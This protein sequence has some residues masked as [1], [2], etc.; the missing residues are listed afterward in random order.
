MKASKF[1]GQLVVGA[2]IAFGLCFQ[3]PL[4]GQESV[5]TDVSS[6]RANELFAKAQEMAGAGQFTKAIS[7]QTVALSILVKAVGEDDLTVQL[8]S[9]RLGTFLLDNG[10]LEGG[11]RLLVELLKKLDEADPP[12]PVAVVAIRA[13]LASAFVDLH[14]FVEAREMLLGT[15][16][17]AKMAY[18]DDR[19]QFLH[20]AAVAAHD[21]QRMGDSQK[22]ETL[23]R[24]VV[25]IAEELP[26]CPRRFLAGSHKSLASILIE[27]NKN[28]EA[29]LELDRAIE[30]GR[31]GGESCEV[32]LAVCLNELATLLHGQAD[33]ESAC[34]NY[35]DAVLLL[36]KLHPEGSMTCSVALSN[37]GQ[38]LVSQGKLEEGMDRLFES[39]DMAIKYREES[40]LDFADILRNAS[41]GAFA[42]K[43]YDYAMLAATE[44]CKLFKAIA[45]ETDHRTGRALYNI[46]LNS[47]F[48]G[49]GPT[50]E[51]F[52]S[53]IKILD[54][55]LL[56]ENQELADAHEGLGIYFSGTNNRNEALRHF[57][58]CIRYASRRL[59]TVLPT[60]PDAEQA[61]YVDY[62]LRH[63][64]PVWTFALENAED[65][66]VTQKSAEWLTNYKWLGYESSARQTSLEKLTKDSKLTG[67]L[68]EL[69]N[70][71][72]AYAMYVP[73]VDE[74]AEHRRRYT[75]LSQQLAVV[76]RELGAEFGTSTAVS[77]WVSL[78][79]LQQS[80]PNNAV[81]VDILR[82]VP[83][84]FDSTTKELVVLPPH[85][86]AW[87]VGG[88]N[89]KTV[90]VVDLGEAEAIDARILNIRRWFQTTTDRDEIL[91]L[92]GEDVVATRLN[93]KLRELARKI[94]APLAQ[95]LEGKEELILSP[96]KELWLAP[97]SALPVD[98][99]GKVLIEKVAIRLVN[100]GRQLTTPTIA[101]D[102]GSNPPV[103]I[104]DPAYDIA[105]FADKQR[106]DIPRENGSTEKTL[107]PGKYWTEQFDRLRGRSDEPRIIA[108][109][110][111]Q[112]N[113]VTAELLLGER[114]SESEV[115][116]IERPSVLCF[117]T[118]GIFLPDPSQF[119]IESPGLSM[120]GDAR[121]ARSRSITRTQQSELDAS[122][123]PLLR[124]GLIL[125]GANKSK[126]SASSFGDGILTGLEI[127]GLDLRGTELVVLSACDSANGEIRN[128]EGVS[129]LQ[130][131]FHL[132]GARYVLGALWGVD[133]L[134]TQVITKWFFENLAAGDSP[135]AALRN[136]QLKWIEDRRANI[137]TPHPA[138]WSGL[139][140]SG[141]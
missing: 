75:E 61:I 27:S 137:G 89:S 52:R 35:E 88:Q 44:S 85:Y 30:I 122:M 71:I 126:T 87:I 108:S 81:F 99:Q 121:N 20:Y 106:Q 120:Q 3:S 5:A 140:I 138:F 43:R 12:D 118:H 59:Q 36:R 112:R 97:W 66:D 95:Y 63:L 6:Q 10:Q 19:M 115:F 133:D 25:A 33:F 84:K 18:R 92:G 2:V 47:M 57:D 77:P 90:G 131:A 37:Y 16:D 69:R 98:D 26:D 39:V 141:N 125:A 4:K 136:A 114:A 56:P 34:K 32:I 129:G 31:G 107:V 46:G 100:S 113:D 132:A 128:G 70:G 7:F 9:Y 15:L 38:S 110:L 1:H 50:E 119:D 54:E 82:F 73:S 76:A 67:K 55:A 101:I 104:G 105:V 139:T 64:A 93:L 13:K 51:S 14:R 135:P 41:T 40:L 23:S 68:V 83:T 65:P 11:I 111:S 48:L 86:V 22:A 62:N 117:V 53:A 80:I 45:G 58:D 8:Q 79:D 91:R 109:L 29:R 74:R 116:K 124:C 78:A 60:L 24:E 94:Y 127:L 103:V 49:E 102:N 123:N 21:F 130:Q 17:T 42:L 72:A 28:G 96:D 134:E